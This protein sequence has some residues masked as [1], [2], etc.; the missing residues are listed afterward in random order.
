MIYKNWYI[1][2]TRRYSEASNSKRQL[3]VRCNSN[4]LE[5]EPSHNLG[6]N[7]RRYLLPLSSYN[8][9][10]VHSKPEKKLLEPTLW[11]GGREIDYLTNLKQSLYIFVQDC[12]KILK[13][14]W[15]GMIAYFTASS[16]ILC[17]EYCWHLF[18]KD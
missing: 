12:L 17:F 7:I 18:L 15:K 2:F 9:A 8:V 5:T 6:E 1:S 16:K 11:K 3:E 4:F 10:F 14:N 13:K